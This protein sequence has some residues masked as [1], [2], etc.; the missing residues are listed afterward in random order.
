MVTTAYEFCLVGSSHHPHKS[1]S[2]ISGYSDSSMG[3][4][5]EG[6]RGRRSD[7]YLKK[8]PSRAACILHLREASADFLFREI[9]RFF[10][11]PKVH[12]PDKPLRHHPLDDRIR[13]AIALVRP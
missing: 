6:I 3:M 8:R 2:Q 10:P 9:R 5:V 11:M 4:P 7:A 13:K 12:E 1:L